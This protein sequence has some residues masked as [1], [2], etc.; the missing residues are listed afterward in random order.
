MKEYTNPMAASYLQEADACKKVLKELQRCTDK[1]KR[2]VAKEHADRRR[3]FET[4]MGYRSEE[5][6]RDAYGWEFITEAQ[7][8]H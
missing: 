6:I 2:R 5:E 1:Y 4:V 8:E 7:F 3:E